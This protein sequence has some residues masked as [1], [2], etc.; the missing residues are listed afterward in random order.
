MGSWT[1]VDNRLAAELL[2]EFRACTGY[3]NR[4]TVIA[5]DLK[6]L[7]SLALGAVGKLT[8]SLYVP[9]RGYSYLGLRD[10]F[11][12][13]APFGI[14]WDQLLQLMSVRIEKSLAPRPA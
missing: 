5:R 12:P 10:Q 3:F 2:E 11:C 9:S 4:A 8:C 6:V 13:R 7:G 14:A 1:R